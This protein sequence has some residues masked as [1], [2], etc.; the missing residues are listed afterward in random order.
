MDSGFPTKEQSLVLFGLP[1]AYMNEREI[2]LDQS[3][4][5]KNPTPKITPPGPQGLGKFIPHKN[6]ELTAEH[7]VTSPNFWVKKNL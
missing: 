2:F 7:F 3:P 5:Q 4:Y 1:W 6:C